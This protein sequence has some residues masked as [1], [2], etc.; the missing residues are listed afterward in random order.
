MYRRRPGSRVG[1]LSLPLRVHRALRC[2]DMLKSTT[3]IVFY[4]AAL[5]AGF[6]LPLT[7]GRLFETVLISDVLGSMV[8]GVILF[9]VFL[10]CYSMTAALFTSSVYVDLRLVLDMEEPMRWAQREHLS[11]NLKRVITLSACIAVMRLVDVYVTISSSLAQR[12]LGQALLWAFY[13]LL[14]LN[15]SLL[16]ACLASYRW[17]WAPGAPGQGALHKAGPL[18]ID[19]DRCSRSVEHASEEACCI[20][21]SCPAA[22]DVVTTLPCGHTFHRSCIQT[23]LRQGRYCPL[24]CSGVSNASEA[25]AWVPPTQPA[26]IAGSGGGSSEVPQ[27]EGS[28][29]PAPFNV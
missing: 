25:H 4:L 11:W 2:F 3:G 20:C 19:L 17:H 12:P 6:G 8:A 5:E 26:P 29:L 28:V 18:M 1:G 16:M 14:A 9:R 23:W 13:C 10:I 24:R 21:L 22:G 7:A 27:D 15:C